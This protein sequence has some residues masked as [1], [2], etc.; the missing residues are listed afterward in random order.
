MAAGFVQDAFGRRAGFVMGIIMMVAGIA[1]A[2][3]SNTPEHF[4]GAK[5]IS[6][7][8]V[9]GML[10]TTQTY[11]SEVTPVPMRGIA[12]SFNIVMMVSLVCPRRLIRIFLSLT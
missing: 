6:G 8:A 9:G 5:I 7:F 1:A 12:L 10:S 3:T 11:V 2:Y 4:L